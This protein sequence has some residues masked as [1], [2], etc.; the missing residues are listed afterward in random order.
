MTN[1]DHKILDYFISFCSNKESLFFDSL[2][3][4]LMEGISG[5]T[6]SYTVQASE[7][8]RSNALVDA[9]HALMKAMD[10]SANDARIFLNLA[11]IFTSLREYSHA[12][13]AYEQARRPG[14]DP[15]FI[16]LRLASVYEL[17]QD[18]SSAEKHYRDALDSKE[19]HFNASQGLV[20]VYI[21]AGRIRDAWDEVKNIINL[22][23]ERYEGIH[24]ASAL[25]LLCNMPI[26]AKELLNKAR[27]KFH[28]RI[29]FHYDYIKSLECAQ[30]YD[31][32]YEYLSSLDE[33]L[34]RE[35]LFFAKE[36]SIIL[37]AL[38]QTNSAMQC[39][40]Y[41]C[42]NFSDLESMYLYSTLLLSTG[43]TDKALEILHDIIDTYSPCLIYFK[44]MYLYASVLK[45][46][47]QSAES[48][49]LY[50]RL[51]QELD[52][53]IDDDNPY[54]PLYIL[55]AYCCEELGIKGVRTDS[56]TKQEDRRT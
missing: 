47:G 29:L 22:Y 31:A 2:L 44:A 28:K 42:S 8:I 7:Y 16:D 37:L 34:V 52:A 41:I 36:N 43:T 40:E 30:Q 10:S 23:P 4:Q 25:Y 15:A 21:S 45:H 20:S 53:I 49:S 55:K 6:L 33:E 48:E 12:I 14:V 24:L 38:G 27:P 50:S 9:K 54:I 32:A 13:S 5:E 51:Y 26:K 17:A 35:N 18:Y 56:W 1:P 46:T 19:Y 3:E 11:G 39:L